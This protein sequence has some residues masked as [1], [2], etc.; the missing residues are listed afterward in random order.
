[1]RFAIVDNH[2]VVN[3]ILWD[4][5]EQYEPPEGTFLCEVPDEVSVGW[6]CVDGV[7]YPP[8]PAEPYPEPEEDPAIQ[9]AKLSALNELTALG[10]SEA[11]ARTI[12]GLPPL[13]T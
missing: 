4:G 5:E 10:V 9:D 6:T 2:V 8:P 1:M 3:V 13:D 11:T 12:V 7:L